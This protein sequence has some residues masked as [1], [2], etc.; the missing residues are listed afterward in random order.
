M[1]GSKVWQVLCRRGHYYSQRI[2]A[3]QPGPTD[4][5]PEVPHRKW[6]S[7][8]NYNRYN[9]TSTSLVTLDQK[10]RS[11]FTMHYIREREPSDT[12]EPSAESREGH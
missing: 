12:D 3:T 11:H 5:T 10:I 1:T 9:N 8:Q 4:H 6:K 2:C 7:T